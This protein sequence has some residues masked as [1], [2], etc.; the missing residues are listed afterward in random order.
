MLLWS[1]RHEI[2]EMT[3][4]WSENFLLSFEIDRNHS[5]NQTF[6]GLRVMEALTLQL[7]HAINDRDSTLFAHFTD[8]VNKIDKRLSKAVKVSK[9]FKERFELHR[10]HFKLVNKFDIKLLKKLDK[11]KKTAIKSQNFTTFYLLNHMGKV[12]RGELPAKIEK[13][14]NNHSTKENSLNLQDISLPVR[15]FP[16]SLPLPKSENF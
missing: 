16:F 13:F 5:V 8:E 14:W 1:V 6:T 9:C 15:I 7:V 2:Y 3:Q 11:L 10:M 12:W 4:V